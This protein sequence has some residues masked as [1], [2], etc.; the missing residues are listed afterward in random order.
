METAF[1]WLSKAVWFVISPESLLILLVLAAWVLLLRG[2]LR[3]AKRVLGFVAVSMIVL[4]TFPV[5]EW[6]LYPLETRFPTNPPLPVKVDGIL[7]LGGAED[8]VRSAA[9]GQFEAGDSAER[10]TAS[11]E[12]AKR[13]PDAKVVFTSG[14]GNPL[15]QE[16]KGS[17]VAKQFYETQGIAPTR[18]IF[19]GESRNT[20]ENVSMSKA[21][22]K[23]GAGET[24][25]L[26]TSAF[27][28]P[29]SVGIFCRAG[30]TVLPYPV[31]HRALRGGLLRV[32]T[33][34]LGNLNNISV[35]MREWIG[36]AAYYL[37]GKTG[38]L[39]PAG[40]R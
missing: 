31:D 22:A 9:W 30:W 14:S 36:L 28:I 7:V 23:P 3:W 4:W 37:T 40:C 38:D 25:V 26:I 10:F 1:F 18:L 29:R 15:A 11:L 27:H 35:G 5:G 32:G 21:L 12:L 6:V 24:W 20:A 8:P 17:T 33:G 39:F 16:F 34:L 13:Y 2:A 19:E